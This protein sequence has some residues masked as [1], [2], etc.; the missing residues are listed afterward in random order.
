MEASGSRIRF[1]LARALLR[2]NQLASLIPFFE[3]HDEDDGPPP[4]RRERGLISWVSPADAMLPIASS[5]PSLAAH[6]DIPSRMVT[7]HDKP[8]KNYGPPQ[9]EILIV[10]YLILEDDVRVKLEAQQQE[11]H[12]R[13]PWQ[14]LVLY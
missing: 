7:N 3:T 4:T 10:I 6:G 14:L 12:L 9:H 11:V 2:L 1:H 5:A 8:K 13:C